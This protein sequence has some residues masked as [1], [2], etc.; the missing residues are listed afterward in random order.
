V[1]RDVTG[2]KSGF[3]VRFGFNSDAHRSLP[4]HCLVSHCLHMLS[5]TLSFSVQCQV[6]RRQAGRL[7]MAVEEVAGVVA[8]RDLCK[9][10]ARLP[11]SEERR[12]TDHV[13]ARAKTRMRSRVNARRVLRSRRRVGRPSQRNGDW[14]RSTTT[15]T[16]EPPHCDAPPREVSLRCCVAR[17]NALASVA[18]VAVAA[19]AAA[20]DMARRFASS[21]CMSRATPAAMRSCSSRCDL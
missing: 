14:H 16:R 10:R 3:R 18:V 7:V 8:E 9:E 17:V 13:T 4:A 15:T 2:A 19:V 12:G 11:C 6:T 5:Y 21:R 20:V 1:T